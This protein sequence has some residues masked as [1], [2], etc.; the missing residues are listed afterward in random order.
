[1]ARWKAAAK[2]ERSSK[3]SKENKDGRPSQWFNDEY[4]SQTHSSLGRQVELWRSLLT[5]EK[6]AEDMLGATDYARAVALSFSRARKLVSISVGRFIPFV[7]L[8]VFLLG[9]GV[10][11]L[12]QY[13]GTGQLIAAV[14]AV[15][16]GLGLSLKG[17]T[18]TLGQIAEKVGDPIWAAELDLAIAEAITRWPAST[19]KLE[20]A[21]QAATAA[22][23]SPSGKKGEKLLSRP[24]SDAEGALW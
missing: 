17:A 20:A 5:E 9:A 24:D 16:S 14:T 19:V 13:E 1:M 11:G 12:T 23:G 18:A 21:A 3:R 10:W 7:A 6:Q 4:L 2:E 15:V 22:G 8:V